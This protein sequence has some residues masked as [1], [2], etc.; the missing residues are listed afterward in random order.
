MYKFII[1]FIILI[2]YI[3]PI[4]DNSNK[5]FVKKSRFGGKLSRGV[6]ANTYINKGELI[7]ENYLL[8]GDD[9]NDILKCGIYRDYVY[10]LTDRD[11]VGFPLGY[12]GLY[13]HSSKNSN[14]YFITIGDKFKIFA[15]K[16]INKGEEILI[17]YGCNHPDTRQHYD[18]A[19]NHNL[20][21]I[22]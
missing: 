2:L 17:C 6:F 4:K 3:F 11:G 13:N 10:S 18:Y 12:G 9:E 21:F 20:K 22:E 14:A 5:I 8:I 15:K 7:E 1:I 19:K 16:N